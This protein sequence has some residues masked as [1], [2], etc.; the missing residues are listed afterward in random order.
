MPAPP[1][2]ASQ[3]YTSSTYHYSV[4]YSGVQ[5]SHKDSSSVEW[6][7]STDAGQYLVVVTA[8]RANGRTP[9]KI[10]GNV[11]NN[12]FPDYS[13]LYDVPGAEV[14]YASGAGSVYDNQAT[15]LFGSASDSRLVVLAG[16]KKGLA[17]AVIG[18]G[19]AA[20]DKSNHPDPSGLP[21]SSLVDSLTNATRWP[22][23]PPH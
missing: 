5:P 21:V 9:Q 15:P 3:S 18:S 19:D 22:G 23:D 6:D 4:E 14:G 20:Q 12:N 8:A 1:L 11:V 16:V 2:Q 10:V 7:L 17:I 13:H